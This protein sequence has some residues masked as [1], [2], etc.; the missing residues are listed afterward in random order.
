MTW[1]A[2]RVQ[3]NKQD[4]GDVTGCSFQNTK[5]IETSYKIELVL[6]YGIVIVKICQDALLP[7]CLQMNVIDRAYP[8]QSYAFLIFSPIQSS[9]VFMGK[10]IENSWPLP[11]G[12]NR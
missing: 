1:H 11:C 6:N 4:F 5:S 8:L 7:C 3:L 10:K 2:K 9:F 12:S